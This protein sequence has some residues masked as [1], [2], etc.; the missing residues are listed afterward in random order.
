MVTV[1]AAL[2]SGSA[3][4]RAPKTASKADGSTC[5]TRSSSARSCQ[6]L[7]AW[8]GS[9]LSREQARRREGRGGGGGPAGVQGEGVGQA[10]GGGGPG[11]G[12]RVRGS[13]TP[14]YLGAL[15]QH[16]EHL[17]AGDGGDGPSREDAA[18][19]RAHVERAKR[20]GLPNEEEHMG[21]T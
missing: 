2:S 1:F 15:A 3:S 8:G 6:A 14:W 11:L 12:R 9:R 17:G 10:R 13:A 20:L 19:D 21:N 5:A 16:G 7:G 4:T 18:V